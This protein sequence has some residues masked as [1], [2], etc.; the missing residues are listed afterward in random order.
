M[1][2][3][4]ALDEYASLEMTTRPDSFQAPAVADLDPSVGHALATFK[5]LCFLYNLFSDHYLLIL[6]G[7][8][9]MANILA[10]GVLLGQMRPGSQNRWNARSYCLQK[11]QTRGVLCCTKS[12]TKV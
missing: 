11:C 8:S 1:V 7:S 5:V 3:A 6:N 4:L 10:N 9:H 2:E 12:K